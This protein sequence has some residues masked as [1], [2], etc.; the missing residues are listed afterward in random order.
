[1]NSYIDSHS[2]TP[3]TIIAKCPIVVAVVNTEMVWVC[4]EERCWVYCK[5][6]AEIK[7]P[8]KRKGGGLWVL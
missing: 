3:T 5:L 1:M 8:A 7:L 4:A 6:D 2:K